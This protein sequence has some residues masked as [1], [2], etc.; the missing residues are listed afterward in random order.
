MKLLAQL[1]RHPLHGLRKLAKRTVRP[2]VEPRR[3]LPAA[4]VA[5]RI[6]QPAQAANAAKRGTDRFPGDAD[7][8]QLYA[9]TLKKA[10]KVPE[11]IA[12]AKKAPNTLR[13]ATTGILSDDH[14]AILMVEE[15]NPGAN[16]RIVHL[17]GGAQQM[18]GILDRK[19]TRLN[20]SHT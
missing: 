19:S 15:V 16:F 18:T 3:P 6:T 17:E 9:Q 14:L 2:G 1:C 7:L 8:W 12:A 5:E 13:T 10:G 4:D 20:S 11:S